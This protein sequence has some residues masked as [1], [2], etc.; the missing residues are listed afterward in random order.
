MLGATA[1]RSAP[2]TEQQG[3]GMP[4]N[5]SIPTLSLPLA[6]S[7]TAHAMKLPEGR[8]M[9]IGTCQL[10]TERTANGNFMRTSNGLQP[11]TVA[12]LVCHRPAMTGG[13]LNCK[14]A[15]PVHGPQRNAGTNTSGIHANDND[16]WKS[17]YP[18]LAIG[19]GI[20]IDLDNSALKKDTYTA[21]KFASVEQGDSSLQIP[22]PI[23]LG[24]PN[25]LYND[26]LDS[27]R[28]LA[29]LVH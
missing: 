28:L 13:T 15:A 14:V 22:A 16:P 23:H 3:H 1:F 17:S 25:P 8:V 18:A 27:N 26:A 19:A 29:T 5:V 6:V 10:K 9:R 2:L 20:V 11:A 24:G 7:S 12:V 21:A 4:F